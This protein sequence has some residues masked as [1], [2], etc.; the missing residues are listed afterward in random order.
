MKDFETRSLSRAYAR[1]VSP[2]VLDERLNVSGTGNL[3]SSL[4]Y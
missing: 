1:E 3:K 4:E 2:P